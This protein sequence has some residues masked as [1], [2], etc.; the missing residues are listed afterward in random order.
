MSL[1][2]MAATSLVVLAICLA[3]VLS[4]MPTARADEPQKSGVS[5]DAVAAL[6]RMGKTLQAK[7]FSFTAHTLRAYAGP[8]GELLHIAHMIKTTIRRP[9]RLA[10]E[11][12]GDDGSKKMLSDGK[13]LVIYA[14]EQKQYVSIP[15]TGDIDSA[16]NT[17]EQRTGTD[18]PLADL[19]TSNPEQSLLAGVTSGGQVGTAMID[20]VPCRHFFFVQAA[21]DMEWELWLEDNDK[22]LPRRV[23]V[24]YR[25]L[26]GRPNFIAQL[27]DWNFSIQP[28]DSEFEF[29]PPAGV[30]Q[31]ELKANTAPAPSK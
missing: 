26:P 3:S 20:G 30:T 6:A 18:F 25:S 31:V 13:N 1:R 21:E 7:Q 22:A 11:V 14:V 15:V 23:F 8:N 12:T 24:T 29:K 5:D 10:V 2:K 19:L 4:A 9:D 28:A 27:S 16:L 17:A